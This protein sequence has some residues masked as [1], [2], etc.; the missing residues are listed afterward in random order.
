MLLFGMSLALA[1]QVVQAAQVIAEEWLL[2]DMDLPGMQIIGFEGAW[3][4]VMMLV[5]AFPLFYLLPGQDGGRF[6]DEQDTL[7]MIGNSSPLLSAL[8]LF[9][10]SCLTYNMAGISVTGAL[11]AVHR[12]M[13]EAFRTCVVWAFGLTVHY[14]YDSNSKFGEVWTPYSPLE[15]G[16]FVC[17]VLGQAIYGVMIRVPGLTYPEG[18]EPAMI[19][20]P[21]SIRNIASPLPPDYEG[22]KHSKVAEFT[23][24]GLE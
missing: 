20:S 1:G 22:Q 15:V 13:L 6:E 11:S 18:S 5:V 10:F 23:A 21:G 16:G 24:E 14:C 4:S 2:T 12:V 19:A 3:G 7:A 8:L 17:I 9:A